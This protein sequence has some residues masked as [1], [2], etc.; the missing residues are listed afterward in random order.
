MC[1]GETPHRPIAAFLLAAAVAALVACGGDGEGG[2]RELTWF[3]QS[4]PGGALEEIAATCEEQSGGRYTIGF[5]LLPSDASQAREQLVRRL[6]AEDDTIDL[7]G[8]DIIWTGEFA[9]AG[10][11]LPVPDQIR[12]AVT[13]NVFD[14]VLETASF[15]GEMVNVPI[16]SNT[17]LLW[18]REDLVPEPPRTWD[19]MIAMAQELGPQ[20]TIQLQ[21]NRYEGLMVWA[22]YM[23]ESAGT[24]I[25]QAPEEIGLE[26]D[27]TE[28]ALSTM[29][30]VSRSSAAATDITTSTEDSA[31]LGFES[32]ES[33]FMINYPFVFPSAQENAPDIF[34]NLAATQ[35]PRVDPSIESAPPIGGINLGVS[36]FSD[37]PELSFE[38]IECLVSAENQ[39]QVAEIEGL[40]PVRSDLYDRPELQE[41]YP[42]FADQIRSSIEDAA[43][44]PSGSAAYQDISLAVQRAIHPT[45]DIDP[46]D[47]TPTYERLVD[48]VEQAIERRGLL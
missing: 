6:G 47:P 27:P 24:T 34:E 9:N 37:S 19:E 22:N 44:R 2:S 14:T 33:A 38:A 5:E 16:W 46:A 20:G 41:V 29:G 8:M 43:P 26:Q 12:P 7:I 45:T 17:Q 39:L 40:P 36:A 31:R 15:E 35:L 23:I 21:A 13:E 18:Y 48:R 11:I 4:Q 25:L 42:G 1:R 30:R 32:G 3:I 28:L 10:W